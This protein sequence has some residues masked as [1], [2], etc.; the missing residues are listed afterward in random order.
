[1]TTKRTFELALS[2]GDKVRWEGVATDGHDAARQ[3][4]TGHPFDCVVGFTEMDD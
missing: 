3:Y 4:E 1:M 2:T